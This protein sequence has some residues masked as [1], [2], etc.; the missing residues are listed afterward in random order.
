MNPYQ[1]LNA[2][3]FWKTAVA[4]QS[5]LIVSELHEK[6]WEIKASDKIATAG[7]C[8]AQHLTTC[9]RGS[10][11]NILDVEP[12]P[13][14]IPSN[15]LS[16]YGYNLFSARYGNIY[17]SRQLLQLIKEAFGLISAKDFVWKKGDRFYDGFRPSVEAN[18][19]VNYD[20]VIKHRQ[21]HIERVKDMLLKADVLIFTLGLTETWRDKETGFVFPTAPGVVA[22]DWIS[23]KFEFVNFSYEE[24][25]K[26][27]IELIDVLS[28]FRKSGPALKY[29]L[30][31]S[32]VPITATASDNHVLVANTA[33]KSILRSVADSLSKR[34]PNIDYFPSY[35]IVTNIAA[36]GVFYSSNLRTV[37]SQGVDVVM[38]YFFKVYG[39]PLES[40]SALETQFSEML[41]SDIVCDEAI[42][43]AFKHE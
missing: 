37:T 23:D 22:G 12:P 36:K 11:F 41:K 5:P 28:E 25:Y 24:I 31:V 6:K 10:Q 17:T 33:S 19:L 15:L 26:D 7:S 38:R 14:Y 27:F 18:G 30:T 34:Q 2:K 39:K 43:E 32:P 40:E 1:K 8:F 35:E 13:Q 20:E 16:S 42:L 21:Y 4:Y 3:S 29:I 9:L